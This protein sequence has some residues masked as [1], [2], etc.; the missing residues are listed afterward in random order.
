[1]YKQPKPIMRQNNY[2]DL[3]SGIQNSIDKV[4]KNPMTVPY[5]NCLNCEHWSLTKD[6]CKL[7][8]AKPPTEI[9][10]YSCPS[11]KDDQDI[12]F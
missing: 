2:A 9:L 10:V 3:Y 7:Y 8:N 11:Y 5:Q 12:P 6:L 1:M 4:I